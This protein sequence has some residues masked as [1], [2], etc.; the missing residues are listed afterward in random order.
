MPVEII[1]NST[2]FFTQYR[3]GNNFTDNP[4]DFTPNLAAEVGE[5][6]QIVQ[7]IDINWGFQ[8]T[9]NDTVDWEFLGGTTFRFKK[10]N[11]GTFLD[12][13]F[14]ANDELNWS[15]ES[16]GTTFD[17]DG[18]VT[19]QSQTWMTVVM[20]SVPT[21]LV[22]VNSQTSGSSLFRGFTDLTAL[23]Y[24]FGLIENQESFNT[25]SKVTNH[26]QSYFCSGL[27]LGGGPVTFIPQGTY[28]DWQTGSGSCERLAN[29]STYVQRFEI[30][31]DFIVSPYYVDGQLS[32]LQDNILPTLLDN[33]QS[34]KYAFSTAFRLTLS[35]VGSE[36]LA[37]IDDVHGSVGWFNQNFNGFTNDYNII[38]VTYEDDASNSADG[39][40]SNGNS[41]ITVE[42][43]KLSGNLISTDKVGAMVSFLAESVDYQNKSTTLT[44]NF[45]YDNNFCLAN[46]TPVSG[47]GIITETTAVITANNIVLT[48]KTT[49]STAQKTVLAG[50]LAPNFLLAISIGDITIDNGN[51]DRVMLI[52]DAIEYETNADIPDLMTLVDARYFAHDENISTLLGSTSLTTWN[53]DGFAGTFEFTLDTNK[54]AFLN[55]FE[56]K[57]VALNPITENFFDLDSFFIDVSNVPVVLGVQ[58]L[59]FTGTRN[60]I[61]A[62]GSQFNDVSIT[63]GAN[64]GGVITYT[65]TFSQKISWQ[66]WI[67]NLDVDNIFYNNTK[68]NNNFNFKTSNYS[69]VSSYQI[70]CAIIANVSGVST[71]GISGDTDYALLFGIIGTFD[72]DLD[73]L[74]TPVWDGTIETFTEDGTVN[75]GGSILTNGDNTLF[76]T[77]WANSVA[78]VVAIPNFWAIHRVEITNQQGYNIEEL[79]S[80]RPRATS[81]LPIPEVSETFLKMVVDSGDIVTTG[82]ISGALVQGSNSYNLSAR[83]QSPNKF[84]TVDLINFRTESETPDTFDPTITKS[85]ATATWN[86]GDGSPLD[87]TNTAS[88]VYTVP[89]EK[90]GYVEVDDFAN[91]TGLSM[92][93]DAINDILDLTDLIAITTIEIEDNTT[94]DGIQSPTHAVTMVKYSVKG[95]TLITTLNVTGLTALA[96]IFDVSGCSILKTLTLPISTGTFSLFDCQNSDLDFFDLTILA[97]L[98]ESVNVKIFLN[99]NSLTVAEVN[100]FLVNLDTISTGGF[101]G[102]LIQIDGTNAAPDGS[103]GGFDGLTA[104]ANL[105]T[106]TFTVNSN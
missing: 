7:E 99:N 66:D 64:V 38:N 104:K 22:G 35:Y 50:K 85:G 12:D 9:V 14:V 17:V 44:D 5:R 49:Y 27:S 93:D 8:A 73:G 21:P 42:I 84:A 40:F 101:A 83:L 55:T 100:Q 15:F 69:G 33:N 105:I 28:K 19:N 25:I 94:L 26:D 52:V 6:S 23:I 41:V 79:S 68:P 47:A 74:S 43:E 70:N 20:A 91:V 75:L 77:T 61:L 65:G 57:I 82:L 2:K 63:T 3:N 24:K 106:K 80:I 78:P 92:I 60:Y 29:P 34:L 72:Y 56:I 97:N 51:S 31:H 62:S 10:T 11:G 37:V 95:S 13:G 39:I 18:D 48:I 54:S 58:Q 45:M 90:I 4:S 89:K 59:E 16:G 30:K 86:Y 76:K 46:G 71:L 88:R 81:Q 67:E 53:E 36:K 98:T 1:P 32:N 96:G 87:V 102:R 103:A